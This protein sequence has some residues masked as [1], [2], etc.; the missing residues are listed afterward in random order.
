MWPG[1]PGDDFRVM[2]S[3]AEDAFASAAVPSML[4]A[5]TAEELGTSWYVNERPTG[6]RASSSPVVFSITTVSGTSAGDAHWVVI[7]WGASAETMYDKP[8]CETA[9]LRTSA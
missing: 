2:P 4:G 8:S 3:L 7:N 5:G 6:T 9:S 1:D